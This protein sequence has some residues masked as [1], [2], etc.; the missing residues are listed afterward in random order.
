MAKFE[1]S[2]YR[3]GHSPRSGFSKEYRT[4]KAM[5][6]RTTNPKSQ[7]Y[8]NYGGRG[9][10]TCER[11]KDFVNFYEDMGD[12]PEGY[13]LERIDNDKGYFPENCKWE[14]AINQARNRRKSS[15]NSSGYV[16]V[17]KK[18]RF[19]S[20]RITVNR[21]QVFLGQFEN[22]EDAVEARKQGEKKYWGRS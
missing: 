11:W 14:T 12:K 1:H 15:A 18:G 7:D 10:Y 8:Y 13:S 20:A 6:N 21:K 22:I 16:G 3:H 2:T 17:G 19:W 4:W 9:I 5:I